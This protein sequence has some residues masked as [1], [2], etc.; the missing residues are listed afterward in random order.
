MRPREAGTLEPGRGVHD[1][2][3]RSYKTNSGSIARGW[4]VE[5]KHQNPI[6]RTRTDS[7]L[8]RW[9]RENYQTAILRQHWTQ[10]RIGKMATLRT[11]EGVDRKEVQKRNRDGAAGLGAWVQAKAESWE[12]A[13]HLAEQAILRD[14]RIGVACGQHLKRTGKASLRKQKLARKRKVF[15]NAAERVRRSQRINNVSAQKPE[16]RKRTFGGSIERLATESWDAL[17]HSRR[18]NDAS[19][20]GRPTQ[21]KSVLAHAGLS[22]DPIHYQSQEELHQ[23]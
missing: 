3:G 5:I 8:R 18:R 7:H 12:R 15:E 16:W 17:E 22:T 19:K 6:N 23:N 4:G 10:K 9:P 14:I 1:A 2:E 21:Q 20:V 11:I 13:P